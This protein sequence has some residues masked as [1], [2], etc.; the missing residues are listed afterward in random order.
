MRHERA[1]EINLEID[2]LVL[3]RFTPPERP[4]SSCVG[5]RGSRGA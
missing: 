2:Q 1:V 4:A 5:L 3:R